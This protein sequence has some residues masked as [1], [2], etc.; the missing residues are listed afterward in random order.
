[1]QIFVNTLT[2][3]IITLDLEASDTM[4]NVKAKIQDKE[5]Y[6]FYFF[7]QF[8]LSLLALSTICNTS[9]TLGHRWRAMATVT[10][11]KTSASRADSTRED[12][13]RHYTR[14]RESLS[15]RL[16]QKFIRKPRIQ[17][18]QT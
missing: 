17:E 10:S 13:A 2:G 15:G 18:L 5:V 4:D 6:F 7:R 8:F 9:L 11:S 12:Y 14:V 16:R 3:K 1:M